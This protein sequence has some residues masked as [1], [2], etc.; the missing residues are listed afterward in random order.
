MSE[1]TQEMM[2]YRLMAHWESSGFFSTP[3]SFNPKPP[4]WEWAPPQ[5]TLLV[6]DH[7]QSDPLNLLLSPCFKEGQSP[8]VAVT[9]GDI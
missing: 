2:T 3:Q 9:T 6:T 1:L 7:L 4:R 8:D 5:A